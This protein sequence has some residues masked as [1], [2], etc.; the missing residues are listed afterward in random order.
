MRLFFIQLLALQSNFGTDER[1]R[2]DERFLEQ[3]DAEEQ[4]GE[5]SAEKHLKG[6]MR[7]VLWW[8]SLVSKPIT[9]IQC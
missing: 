1:F 8:P 3:D 7:M 2:I 5:A 9:L 6:V 4:S